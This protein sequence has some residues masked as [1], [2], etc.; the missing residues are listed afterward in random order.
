MNGHQNLA[1]S[2][3]SAAIYLHWRNILL[4]FN[5]ESRV[6]HSRST[7]SLKCSD[8][9]SGSA[10]WGAEWN[11]LIEKINYWHS[12]FASFGR[13]RWKGRVWRESRRYFIRT[14]YTSIKGFQFKFIQYFHIIQ[15]GILLIF[16]TMSQHMIDLRLL[17]QCGCCI[18][19]VN[20]YPIPATMIS[21]V[22]KWPHDR[23]L[24]NRDDIH[25]QSVRFDNIL[26]WMMDP[27]EKENLNRIHIQQH[28]ARQSMIDGPKGAMNAKQVHSKHFATRQM[29]I[30]TLKRVLYRMT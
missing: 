3:T 27:E 4:I 28:R 25:H 14:N 9:Q 10:T 30:H 1:M 12:M 2:Q 6:Y 16:T 11:G 7:L 18:T 5:N 19:Q 21:R 17:Q 22:I 20:G 15:A 24:S 29:K 23:M 13:E 8:T 26:A